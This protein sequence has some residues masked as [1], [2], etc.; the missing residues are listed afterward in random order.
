[1]FGNYENILDWFVDSFLHT[2]AVKSIMV[3]GF[4]IIIFLVILKLF[5][6]LIQ[7]IKNLWKK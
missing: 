2:M 5:I 4:I 3:Y 1:M 7:Q 6:S